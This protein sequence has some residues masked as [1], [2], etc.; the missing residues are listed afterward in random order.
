MLE[1]ICRQ[2]LSNWIDMVERNHG[3][4]MWEIERLDIRWREY[5]KELEK[6]LDKILPGY[7]VLQVIRYIEQSNY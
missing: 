1:S 7:Y 5:K 4:K 3:K 2:A 6:G